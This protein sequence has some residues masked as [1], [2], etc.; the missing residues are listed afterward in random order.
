M[1][2][3]SLEQVVFRMDVLHRLQADGARV[4]NSPRAI[5]TCVDKYLATANLQAAGLAVPATVVCQHADA[6]LEAFTHARRR[7]GGQAGGLARGP[8][9]GGVSDPTWRGAPFRTLER[10][11]CVLYAVQ[12]HVIRIPGWD[13]RVLVVG[14]KGADCNEIFAWRSA[15]GR[16][17]VGA[18][19]QRR[20]ST[21]QSP[22]RPGTW[23][24]GRHRL[25]GA[26]VAGVDL[27]PGSGR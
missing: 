4:M 17:N 13:L 1:P 20:D 12:Q 25:L 3:G 9:H 2:P 18:G 11:Q 16:T 5:E 8:R 6:A 27:V 10:T 22:R 21:T 7:C 23:Q 26:A 24:F 15:I 14:G 19:R